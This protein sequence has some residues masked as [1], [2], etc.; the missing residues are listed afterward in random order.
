MFARLGPWPEKI[1]EFRPDQVTAVRR[2]LAAY[3]AGARVVLLDAPTGSGKTLVAEA[4]RRATEARGL[5]VCSDRG[6][7]DQFLRDFPEAHVIKGRRNYPTMMGGGNVT[8]DDCTRGEK[9]PS[10]CRWCDP[11]KE[12]PYSLAKA[13]ALMGPLTC[14]NTAYLLAEANTA[15]AFSGWPLIVADE[16]DRLESA[17]MSAVEVE[18][19]RTRL[20]RLGLR[21]P[22]LTTTAGWAEWIRRVL[23]PR[24]TEQADWLLGRLDE[25]PE[26]VALA[27]E[28]RSAARLR[29][30]LES[31][32]AGLTA[33]KWV[34]VSRDKGGVAF[35]PIRVDDLGEAW[36]WSH[37]ARWLCM[38]A[39]ILS[40]PSLLKALGWPLDRGDWTV[41][42]MPMSFPV[43]HRR[44]YACGV[45][46]VTRANRA[47]ALPELAKALRRIMD[48]HPRERILVHTVSYATS[49]ALEFELRGVRRIIT[50]DNAD[51]KG[52]ALAE[53]RRTPDGVLLAAGMD[54]GVDLP[55]DLC[56]VLVVLKV[57]W[58]DL[59]D[60]QVKA[61]VEGTG[62]TGRAARWEGQQWYREQTLRS[63]VQMTG[64]GVRH[65]EDW[66]V[67]Y[68]LD[69]QFD[70]VLAQSS[71]M[72][73]GWWREAVEELS[74]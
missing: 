71:A 20:E 46:D 66:C 54:R 60:A 36:L 61:R 43:E 17:L 5:Y 1:T 16:A 26:D 48:R 31:A 56:R 45:T 41:V 58:P 65:I 6:L 12:C 49:R 10:S 7:Q 11:V 57:P 59:G 18:V 37:S 4:V 52:M 38:S 27:R 21:D 50:F 15:G 34:A 13:A 14:A 33:G 70:R 63:L 72:L 73:P 68:I 53:Y 23:L 40:A 64:R 42:R 62:L 22:G 74:L 2:V 24:V 39:T 47:E 67:T 9:S 51:E 25:D 55:D 35:K 32:E 30:T 3:A 8:A 29:D 69:R 44:I 19:T 28:S